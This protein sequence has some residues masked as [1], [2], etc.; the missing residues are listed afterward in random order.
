MQI[1]YIR[2]HYIEQPSFWY[3]ILRMLPAKLLRL[4]LLHSSLYQRFPENQG[5]YQGI[6]IE[7]PFDEKGTQKM[8]EKQVWRALRKD[9]E[10]QRES[11]ERPIFLLQGSLF[12]LYRNQEEEISCY[13]FGKEWEGK[14]VEREEENSPV[15]QLL[16]RHRY[17]EWMKLFF[18]KELVEYYRI[19]NGIRRKVF[20]LVIIEGEKEETKRAIEL[21]FREQNYMLVITEQPELY[22][23]FFDQIYEETGLSVMTAE[24]MPVLKTEE[25]EQT[26]IVDMR[27]LFAN[28]GRMR[29]TQNGIWIEQQILTAIL[30]ETTL[31]CHGNIEEEKL[32]ERKEEDQLYLRKII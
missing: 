9:I 3:C 18:L 28:T 21:L 30:M 32:K 14:L 22:E 10:K 13:P 26:I 8:K 19:L 31:D 7:L 24:K 23:R 15:G 6:E 17:L 11:Y 27:Q 29:V 12:R 4:F 16:C 5:D 1:T 25:R 2:Y 20:R